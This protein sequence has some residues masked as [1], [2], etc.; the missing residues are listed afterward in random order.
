MP[1]MASWASDM[2]S[3]H[4]ALCC[5]PSPGLNWLVISLHWLLIS[6][7]YTYT[8]WNDEVNGKILI[9]Q[10]IVLLGAMEFLNIHITVLKKAT[11]AAFVYFAPW[12]WKYLVNWSFG[13]NKYTLLYLVLHV[14][15]PW[16]LIEQHHLIDFKK[17]VITVIG[18]V[19][20]QPFQ[21]C[22]TF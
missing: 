19:I 11:K 6:Y 2:P 20:F 21:P 3:R 22:L 14:L 1:G 15:Y 4:L 5:S 10:I 18:C 16:A 7:I 8:Q 12:S 13:S 17:R 9:L